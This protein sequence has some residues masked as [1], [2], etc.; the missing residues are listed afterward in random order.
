MTFLQIY[1]IAGLVILGLMT[2]LWLVSLLLKDSSIV[3]IFWGAG[4]VL[5]AWVCFAFT[6]GFVWRKALLVALVTIWGLRLSLYILS[7]N[8][9]KGEDF[10]YRK[11]REEAGGQW[12]WRSFFKVFALQG[13]LMWIIS[14]PL[15]AAQ[16]GR[17]PAHLTVLD[18]IAVLVWAVGFFFEATGDWQM[19]RFR[20]N[21]ANKGK[22]LNTG[23]WRYTRHPNY[24][25]DATQWWAYYLLALAAGGFWT[26]YSP[27]LMTLL[28][29]R[30]SGVALLEKTLQE[31]KPQYR[32]YI[33]TT[34]AFIPWFP[35]KRPLD[36]GRSAPR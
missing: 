1:G 7:R 23:V 6:D 26:V 8:W 4:F 34:S 27:I 21:P 13:L 32:E 9:G 17:L 25:G 15:L 3:D 10:R 35:K 12:W 20:A 29:L 18:L 31:T 5:I 24:F 36:P 14:I 30:V 16:F 33:E 28:L 11:W 2:A 19:A 22:V